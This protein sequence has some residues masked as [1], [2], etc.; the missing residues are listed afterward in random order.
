MLYNNARIFPVVMLDKNGIALYLISLMVL[1][2]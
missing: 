1:S 2:L